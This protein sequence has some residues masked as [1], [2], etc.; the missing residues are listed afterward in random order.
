MN[1]HGVLCFISP[2]AVKKPMNHAA[3][4]FEIKVING[5]YW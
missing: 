3:S 4:H 2:I 5:E 1:V